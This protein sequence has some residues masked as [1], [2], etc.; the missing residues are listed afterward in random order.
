[1]PW[2]IYRL[3]RSAI[4]RESHLDQHQRGMQ[5]HRKLGSCHIVQAPADHNED[6]TTLFNRF[7]RA[8]TH[9]KQ[10]HVVFVGDLPLRIKARFVCMFTNITNIECGFD[11]TN[12]IFD[13]P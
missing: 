9:F 3:C 13:H 8:T 6:V 2:L 1:M 7:Q 11:G 5:Y 10:K 4:S 12:K